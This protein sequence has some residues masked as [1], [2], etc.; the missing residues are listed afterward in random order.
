MHPGQIPAGYYTLLPHH[1]HIELHHPPHDH[2]G[3]EYV[4]VNVVNVVRRDPYVP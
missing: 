4:L 2:Q 3:E 1:Y